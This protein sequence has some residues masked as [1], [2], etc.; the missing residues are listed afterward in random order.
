MTP[1]VRAKVRT[2][3][4]LRCI[5]KTN[6]QEWVEACR[7]TNE[8]I[9]KA[10]KESWKEALEGTM[11]NTGGKD[12]QKVIKGLNSTPEANSPSEAISHNGHTITDAKA[13]A[14]IF[15]SHYARVSNLPMTVE[16]RNLIKEFKKR[17]DSPSTDNKMCSRLT[18]GELISAVWMMKCKVA[19]DPDDIPP[20]F[21]K[22]L[23]PIALQELLEIFNTLFQ[24]ADWP[25]IWQVATI[26]RVLKTGKS[27][28][29]IASYRPISLTSRIVKLLKCI[30]AHR[31]YYIA[32]S[33]HLF[34]CFQAGL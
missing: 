3:N 9:N 19:A 28:S 13:K 8:A 1:H 32:E 33:N 23:G 20:T 30:L 21:L 17:I 14:N 31:L 4:R 7:K 5:I 34:S 16:D 12:M 18:M 15:V 6:Q 11:A 25:R 10:K 24:Y 22:A 2:R 26:I 29:E 27:A